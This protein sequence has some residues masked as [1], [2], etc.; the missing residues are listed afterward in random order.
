MRF[1]LTTNTCCVAVHSTLVHKNAWLVCVFDIHTACVVIRSRTCPVQLG[2]KNSDRYLFLE[3]DSEGGSQRL[4][5]VR[6][7]KTASLSNTSSCLYVVGPRS[8]LGTSTYPGY[9]AARP[10]NV[11]CYQMSTIQRNRLSPR[12]RKALAARSPQPLRQ[13]RW[14]P[15]QE[16]ENGRA[17]RALNTTPRLAWEPDIEL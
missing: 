11:R 14:K 15:V 6:L 16:Q 10:V 9:A 7:K 8:D 2:T 12:S 5:V 13:A 3:R 17:P 4:K 1:R